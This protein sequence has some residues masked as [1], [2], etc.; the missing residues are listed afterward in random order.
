MYFPEDMNFQYFFFDTYIGYFLQL[1]PVALIA[2]LTCFFVRRKKHREE[3]W[4]TL[5]ASL[6]ISYIA[7]VAAITLFQNILSDIYYWLFYHSPSGRTYQWFTFYFSFRLDFFRDITMENIANVLLFLPYGILY[8]F[9]NRNA[10]WKRTLGMG[11]LTSF[12]IEMMQP[13]VGRI[14]DLNDVVLNSIGV[15]ISTAVFFGIWTLRQ[16]KSRP[17]N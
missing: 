16:R 6:F 12:A 2:G 15:V 5:L 11:I 13:V 10:G 3:T 1:I 17:L 7:S 4:R 14:F 8:P 9:F